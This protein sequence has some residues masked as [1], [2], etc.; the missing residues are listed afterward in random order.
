MMHVF[1]ARRGAFLAYS[2]AA[3]GLALWP[4]PAA[5]QAGVR[6]SRRRRSGQSAELP[7]GPLYL[8]GARPF[9]RSRTPRPRPVALSL[10]AE[11]EG[12]A[13]L[14]TLGAEGA[15]AHGGSAVAEIGPLADASTRPSTCCA[16]TPGSRRREP[17]TAVHTH[18]GTEAFYRAGGAAEP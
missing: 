13:W 4:A 6:P 8:A 9:P 15:P 5:A 7:A 11:A 10:P 17:K 18:P 16:S 2:L 14:F 1:G 12:K 3:I